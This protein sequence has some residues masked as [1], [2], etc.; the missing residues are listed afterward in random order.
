MDLHDE[1]EYIY[2]VTRPG[3]KIAIEKTKTTCR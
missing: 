2:L 1:A 3:I